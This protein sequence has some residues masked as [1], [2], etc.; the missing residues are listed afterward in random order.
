M[1]EWWT[2]HLSDLLL[3]SARTYYRL[4]E[5]YNAGIW[6]AQILAIGLG[7]GILVLLRRGGSR[8]IP[9]VLAAGWL[10]I[11][12]AFLAKRYATINWSATQFSWAFGVEAALLLGFGVARESFAVEPPV[13]TATRMGVGIAAFALLVQ[14]LLDPLL[15]HTWRG[16]QLFLLFPDPTAIG[17]LGLLIGTRVRHRW[18]LMIVPVLWCLYTA[19]FLLAMQSPDWWVAPLAAGL[20]VVFA[21]RSKR[22]GTSPAPTTLR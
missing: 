17:T 13:G 5:L 6:P 10:W 20:T 21:A 15:R 7:I 16:A 9:L 22:A 8:A 1:S 3:F 18:I 14:P 2:Y 19:I 11:A 4:I 12:V